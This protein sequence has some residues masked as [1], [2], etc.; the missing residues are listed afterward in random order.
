PEVFSAR[1]ARP[2]GGAGRP[3]RRAALPRLRCVGVRDG[4]GAA[5]GRRL[6]RVIPRIFHQIWLGDGP[7]PREYEGYQR[8]W[9][10][11]NPGWELRVWT[12][13]DLPGDLRRP[14]AAERLRAPAE[15]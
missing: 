10:K 11:H 15:R 8:S 4:P 5:R 14:E 7:L 13:A 2:D 6:H 1:A 3:R 9:T 12:E